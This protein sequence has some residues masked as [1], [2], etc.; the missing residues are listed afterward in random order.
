[1]K[2][3]EN[4]NITLR[5]GDSDSITVAVRGGEEL[6]VS[7][8]LLE[9]TVRRTAEDEAEVHKEIREFPEGKAV[10]PFE[11]EDTEGMDFGR[12][13]YDIQLTDVGG[14]VLHLVPPRP[15]QPLPKFTLTQEVTHNG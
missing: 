5:R 15:E 11:P 7:G 13:V 9:L 6:L 2:I 4:L 3:D 12:Y 10:I 14:R 8:A 1:M